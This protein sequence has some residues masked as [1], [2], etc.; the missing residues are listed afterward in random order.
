[1]EEMAKSIKTVAGAMCILLPQFERG[2]E[3]SDETEWVS[4]SEKGSVRTS[5]T[6]GSD[7]SSKLDRHAIS[8]RGRLI[9]GGGGG[10]SENDDATRRKERNSSIGDVQHAIALKKRVHKVHVT[11]ALHHLMV[12]KL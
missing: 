9:E 11:L 10:G 2:T 6:S 7:T 5:G 4:Y 12:C 1:M 8:V 3:G